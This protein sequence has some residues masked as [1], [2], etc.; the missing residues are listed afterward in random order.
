MLFG[1]QSRLVELERL[2]GEWQDERVNLNKL[3]QQVEAKLSES[4][5]TIDERDASLQ[6]S[7][8]FIAQLQV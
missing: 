6:K 4:R 7:H 5:A 1:L 3:V 8:D 2:R